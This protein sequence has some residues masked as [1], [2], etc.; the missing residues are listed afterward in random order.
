MPNWCIN[1][2]E[3]TGPEEALQRLKEAAKGDDPKVVFS[4]QSLHP[5]PESLHHVSSGSEEMGYEIKY[6]DKWKRIIQY[7]WVPEEV[8]TQEQLIEFFTEHYP[9]EM[10]LAEVYKDNVDKYGHPTW[11]G[12]KV[13]NWGTKW[14][15]H[16][17]VHEVEVDEPEMW[18][19]SFDSAWSPPEAAIHKIAADYPE[20]Q[21]EISY[22]EPGCDFAGFTTWEKGV[23]TSNVGGTIA[24][25][26]PELWADYQ[27]E[28]QD[29]K[30][31]EEAT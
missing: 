16:V 13:H 17:E 7:S 3:I 20:L 9:K 31:E 22:H 29:E 25:V 19:L 21:F 6:T 1:R 10:R 26:M 8:K 2:L 28:W 15:L 14:D 5:C 30:D 27:R 24:E 12:W 4:L 23:V 18:V 11:Y